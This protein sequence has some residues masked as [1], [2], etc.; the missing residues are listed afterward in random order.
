MASP[1]SVPANEA[2]RL[3]RLHE[4]LVLDTAPEP[5]F[6]SLARLASEVCGTPIALLS[7]VDDRRQ[8]FKANVGLSEI[9]EGP[10]EEAFCAHTILGDGLF[11]VADATRDPRFADNPMV[12]GAPDIRFYAG[13]P[14]VLPGG[15]RV[16]SLCVI[17]RQ[18]H[19][20][21]DL[22]QARMLRSLA[23]IAVQAL[24][25][26]SAL[27]AKALAVRSRFEITL[28]ESEATHRAI[29][30]M[31]SEMIS[32]AQADGTLAY[33]NPAYA[34]HF[35]RQPEQM[36]GAQ[37]FEFVVP[38][39]RAAV[40]AQVAQVLATGQ[41]H[42]GENRMLAADGTERWVS[43]T[44]SAQ[45][46]A[47][48]HVLL[49]SVGRDVTD[50]KRAEQ[51]L[52][53]S[54][55]FL[56]RTGRVAGVG[57]WELDLLNS[58]VTWSEETRRIHEVPGDYEPQLE[59]AINF[60]APASRPVIEEAV[61]VAM[62]LGKPWDIE[63]SLITAT[64]RPIE[65]RAQGEVEF[66]AGRAV[67]LVG[68]FQDITERK[69]L[70]KRVADS[71]RFLRQIADSLP[72]RIA[73]TDAQ[74]RYGFVNLAHIK[75]FGRPREEIIGRTRSEL[76]LAGTD[77]GIDARVSAVMAGRAQRFEFEET[78]DG[79]LRRI[80]S[81]LIPDVAD[82]GQVRGFFSTGV[83]ITERDAAQQHL[84]R[85]TATL[86][87]VTEAIPVIVGAL[88]RDLRYR[89]VNGAFERW[90]GLSREQVVGRRADEVLPLADFERSLPWAE[91]ALAGETVQFERGYPN[92][93]GKPHL[94]VSYVP[95]RMEDGRV[96]GFVAV[97]VDVTLQHREQTRLQELA[98]RDPLTGLLNRAGFEERLQQHLQRGQ[99]PMLALLYIDLDRFKPVNDQHGHAVGDQVL[100]LFAQR[101]TRLV[102]PS[103]AVA[104]L[105]GDEFAVL[106][107]QVRE[108]RSAHTV[109]DT[110]I[111]AAGVP[112]NLHG[113]RVNIGA[114]VGV[115]TG[116]DAALGG[117]EFVARADAQ[118]YRAKAAGRG[119]RASL[120]DRLD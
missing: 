111:A 35:G 46:D 24:A 73:Y 86:H 39:D 14:L 72:I 114:S 60:Y 49:H 119:Q 98:Q 43:W 117:A 10:R 15:E 95:L 22:A 87:S 27:L 84:Q 99:G 104:R 100:R 74:L 5:I 45:R 88:D 58:K 2:E 80:E 68:A 67:R 7:L 85:Q 115:A 26:R 92:R 21:L 102:R 76:A 108:V 31:Q 47:E 94:A 96:D 18:A 55:A 106:L 69:Q 33:A 61:R 30:D 11:E 52:R 32:L 51:A 110:I 78:V 103:D 23:N 13:T 40:Q 101:L 8:W 42:S 90:Y 81:Q 116:A 9:T 16:G 36:T 1:P 77:A 93:E 41:S 113:L 4:L 112:F 75:R 44:N 71:E 29:V 37:L 109:A 6:D 105:G 65:V 97:A 66:E 79:E 34:R 17:D 59:T 56:A 70:E 48:G 19:Q 89:F 118:L 91:R 38:S 20:P 63:L 3:A 57:G 53:A 82:N 28:A 62:E 25:M 12:T 120:F 83:D 54:Q 50:R 107:P 64:G